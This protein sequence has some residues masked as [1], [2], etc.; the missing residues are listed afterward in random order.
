MENPTPFDLNAAIRRWQQELGASPA[1]G[2]ENLEELASHLR[3]S[4]QKLKGDG[5]L[6]EEAFRMATRRR[7]E[8]GELEREYAKVNPA[9]NRSLPVILF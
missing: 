5:F 8:R 1:F 9:A 7:G 6:E 4:V 3:A 2:A